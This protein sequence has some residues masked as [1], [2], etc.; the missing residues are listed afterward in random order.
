MG[1]SQQEYWSGLPFPP[2]VDHILSEFFTLICLYWVA[3]PGM[4]HRFIELQKPL[5]HK[6]A[7]IHERIQYICA[8]AME[9]YSAIKIK[10]CYL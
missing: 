8:Y 3:L 1:F 2:P 9:Y 6:K 5:L 4:A 10:Y 7:V